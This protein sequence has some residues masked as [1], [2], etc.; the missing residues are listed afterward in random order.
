MSLAQIHIC[1][2]L[3]P[4]HS[5]SR[6]RLSELLALQPEVSEADGFSALPVFRNPDAQGHI[7]PQYE[8]INLV[9][10]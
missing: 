8:C 5:P 2:K 10:M 9:R 6:Q 1:K 4:T 7:I 3:L